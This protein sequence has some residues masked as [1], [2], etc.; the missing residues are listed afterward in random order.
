[1][2]IVGVSLDY[3]QAKLEQFLQANPIPWP[4]IFFPGERNPLATRYGVTIIPFM[5]LVDQDGNLAELDARGPEIEPAV[6]RALGLTAPRRGPGAMLAER[7]SQW[8]IF[9]VLSC[10]AWLFLT[11][12]WGAAV[13]LALVEAGLRRAFRKTAPPA[14]PR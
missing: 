12:G 4:Q 11:C 14:H 2:D 13:A 8:A 10:P 9:T 1:L 7:L 6:A 5:M 3:E